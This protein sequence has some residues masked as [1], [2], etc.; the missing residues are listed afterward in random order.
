MVYQNTQILSE[1]R[2]QMGAV[3]LGR[4]LGIYYVDTPHLCLTPEL[5]LTISLKIGVC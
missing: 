4:Y 3:F 5:S 2:S 1:R